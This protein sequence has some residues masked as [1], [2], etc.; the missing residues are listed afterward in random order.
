MSTTGGLNGT[1]TKTLR[2]GSSLFHKSSGKITV[3]RVP[4]GSITQEAMEVTTQEAKAMSTKEAMEVSTKEAGTK[5]KSS[6]RA[7][8]ERYGGRSTRTGKTMQ[9]E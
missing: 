8:R 1:L 2:R 6:T 5:R 9:V 3:G 7:S 4:V